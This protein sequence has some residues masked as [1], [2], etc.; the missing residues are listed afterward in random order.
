MQVKTPISIKLTSTS[1]SLMNKQSLKNRFH[2]NTLPSRMFIF[3]ATLA[4]C[5]SIWKCVGPRKP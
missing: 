1:T 2:P 3:N 5:N 4:E